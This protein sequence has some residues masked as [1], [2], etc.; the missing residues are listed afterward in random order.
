[1]NVLSTHGDEGRPPTSYGCGSSFGSGYC[2]EQGCAKNAD[3][4]NAGA[5]C[6]SVGGAPK[7]MPHTAPYAAPGSRGSLPGSYPNYSKLGE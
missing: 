3:H 5:A 7:T 1:M 4:G 2:T 6:Y